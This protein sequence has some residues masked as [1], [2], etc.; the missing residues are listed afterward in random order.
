MGEK[1]IDGDFINY[2]IRAGDLRLIEEKA[3]DAGIDYEW[4]REH[5]LKPRQEQ[6]VEGRDLSEQEGKKIITGA[7]A[8]IAQTTEE[9]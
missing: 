1:S 2:G 6:S 4:L 7:I 3:R 5:I 8:K 9:A